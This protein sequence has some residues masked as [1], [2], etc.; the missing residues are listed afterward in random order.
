VAENCT[1]SSADCPA[2]GFVLAGT[3]CRAAANECDVAEACTGLSAACPA[4]AKQPTGTGCDDNDT[5]T[6]TDQCNGS[7]TCV[8]AD[9]LD[10]DDGYACTADSCDPMGGCVNDDAPASGCLTAEKSLVLI[11]DNADDDSR[12]RLLYKWI[13]GAELS[14]MDLADPTSSDGYALCVYAGTANALIVDAAI[15]PGASWSE[16]G[17]KGYKF[18]GTSPNGLSLALLKGGDAGKSKALAKGKGATLP[19]PTLPVAYPVTV[20]L[21]KDGAPLCLES[22]FT[23]AN[24]KKN[25]AKQFKAKF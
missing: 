8:G 23:S 19:D 5:C 6:M 2:D 3:P 16:I 4:D 10:C 21:K 24:E 14:Q 11:K 20:Q 1:G 9:P 18:K 13:K 15:P 12:D 7:G 17:D 25:E 22:T